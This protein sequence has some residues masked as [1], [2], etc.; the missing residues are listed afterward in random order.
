MRK[1]VQE[2]LAEL[3]STAP[4][5]GGGAA[6]ALAGS[7][8]AALVEMVAGISHKAAPQEERLEKIRGEAQGLR[9]KLTE[10]IEEDSAAYAEVARALSMPKATE[11]EKAARRAALAG[12]LRRAAEVPL[13]T[14]RRAMRVLDLCEELAPLASRHLHSDIA[15]AAQLAR[16]AARAAL[17][18]VDANCLWIKDQEFLTKMH[19]LRVELNREADRKTTR[20]LAP[21]EAKLSAWL[22]ERDS[23]P[24]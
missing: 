15:T 14:A 2:F 20:L 22:G 8:A 11:E 10:A 16:A 18:N 19:P 9:L 3:G 4:A 24:H 5:P 21:L 17:Y 12:A 6:A 13:A 23:N 7:M 1:S